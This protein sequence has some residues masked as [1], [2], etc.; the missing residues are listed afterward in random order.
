TLLTVY[1]QRNE[2]SV[3]YPRTPTKH[4]TFIPPGVGADSSCPYPLITKSV[5]V[6]YHFV[7]VYI[8]AGTINRPLQQL[9][10]CHNVANGL[11][12]TQRTLREISTNTYETPHIHSAR[13]RG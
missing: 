4:P 2:H 7:V 1:Q 3:K 12:T 10:V 5:Y 8:Y 6:R 11:P 13:R 9:V